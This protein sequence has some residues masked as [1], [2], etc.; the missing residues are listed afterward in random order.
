[1]HAIRSSTSDRMPMMCDGSSCSNGN[2]KPVTLVRIVNN[3]K[4]AVSPGILP[5]PS[6]PNMTIMPEAIAIRL[7]RTWTKVKVDT[8]SPTIMTNK[9]PCQNRTNATIRPAELPPLANR[10][11]S[12]SGMRGRSKRGLGDI[13]EKAVQRRHHLGALAD[14]TADSLDRAGTDIADGKH[15]GHGGFELRARTTQ[16]EVRLGAGDDEARPIERD[17]TTIE[18]AGGGIGADEQEEISD[19]GGAFLAG[20]PA[21]PADALER[22]I[23]PALQR[24]DFAVEQEIDVRRGLDAF[25][26]IAR[27]AGTQTAAANDHGDLARVTRQEH[28]GLSGRV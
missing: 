1:M 28:R 24:R 21:A 7:I 19:I 4:I 20:Q 11:T 9:S 23:M 25:D 27:H 12:N 16:V 13:A 17:A 5:P 8:L 15:A 14:R 22:G 10:S 6:M 18:P 2:M 3:R 26:Q